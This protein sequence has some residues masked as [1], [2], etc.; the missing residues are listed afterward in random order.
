MSYGTRRP[1]RN[2]KM[3]GLP[4]P[5]V[6]PSTSALGFLQRLPFKFGSTLRYK[7]SAADLQDNPGAHRAE[8]GNMEEAEPLIEEY[9]SG[10]GDGEN[11]QTRI[12]RERSSTQGSGATSDSFRSRGDLF[13][14]DGEDDAVPLPDEFAISLTTRSG[15]DDRS[16]G[17]TK[18]SKGKGRGGARGG[19]NILA[20]TR[21]RAS[22]SSSRSLA[23]MS[24]LGEPSPLA[25]GS[26]HS[27]S[28]NMQATE[29][30]S[31]SDLAREEERARKE[32]EAELGAKREAAGRLAV[33][34]GLSVSDALA[35]SQ[36]AE[37]SSSTGKSAAE[38]K[39]TVHLDAESPTSFTSSPD[40]QIET[41]AL[42][43]HVPNSCV[44]HPRGSC[45]A[46]TPKSVS[47]GAAETTFVGARLPGF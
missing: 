32:E 7:P 8:L 35:S 15:P 9:H 38:H 43:T 22:H 6:I 27:S 42:E 30:Q 24:S 36:Q 46:P 1:K 3:D 5:T 31:L 28:V 37:N 25:L 13:P 33:K 11:P 16:S 34:R 26:S 41:S 17:T 47:S 2:G 14:S 18:S 20:R 39:S 45:V 10:D 21:S 19:A 29:E 4:D 12:T 44:S 23:A 40:A